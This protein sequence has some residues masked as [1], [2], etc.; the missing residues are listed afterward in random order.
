MKSSL[1]LVLVGVIATFALTA[2]PASAQNWTDYRYSFF[3]ETH[4]SPMQIKGMADVHVSDYQTQAL[5]GRMELPLGEG[6]TN[7]PL[8]P[9]LKLGF[10]ANIA[11]FL[12]LTADFSVN[13]S[14]M[15][16]LT[17]TGGADIYLVELENFR[18]GAMVRMGFMMANLNAGKTQTLPGSTPPIIVDGVGTFNNGDDISAELTGIVTQAGIVNEFYV[19]PDL[20]VR[21]EA[22]FQY[23]YINELTIVSG[24]GAERIELP[25]DN[26][27]VL[28]ADA[29][30]YEPAG[31][32]PQGQSLGLTAAVGLVFRY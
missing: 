28:K 21:F 15:L 32:D 9:G 11:P 26:D 5:E 22:G 27:A 8:M 7:N 10:N 6:N 1:K 20:G 17:F 31:I 14:S 12:D 23:A 13:F 2:T 4:T 19:T 30:S 29:S 24:T 18:M 16:V 25:V 3:L